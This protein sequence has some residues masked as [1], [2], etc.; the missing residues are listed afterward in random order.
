MLIEK[1]P[2][3]AKFL[4][5]DFLHLNLARYMLNLLKLQQNLDGAA[6]VFSIVKT[7]LRFDKC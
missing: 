1:W 7:Q 2:F 6:I 3:A 4:L 5:S